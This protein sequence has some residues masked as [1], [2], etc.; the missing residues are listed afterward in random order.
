MEE[1][2]NQEKF[3]FDFL[4]EKEDKRTLKKANVIGAVVL[5]LIG[6]AIG[7]YFIFGT[8]SDSEEQTEA[9]AQENDGQ[10]EEIQDT[11]ANY[12]T[13]NMN[14]VDSENQTDDNT[15]S[16]EQNTNDNTVDEN[17]ATDTTNDYNTTD[18]SNMQY[19]IVSNAFK[20]EEY[21]NNEVDKLKNEGYNAVIAGQNSAGLYIV[22]YEGFSDIESAKTKL[23][24]I[25]EK[26]PN[27]WIYKKQ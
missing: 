22:A 18:T 3:G 5:L 4:E 14:I 21:A 15:T 12:E 19:F 11:V 2:Q 20:N 17:N 24:E 25:R 8:N 1:M 9:V 26:D 27:A 7:S 6:I 10:Q 16:E 23:N 13:E